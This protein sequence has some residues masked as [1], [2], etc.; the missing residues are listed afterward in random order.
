[1]CNVPRNVIEGDSNE[2][3]LPC[4]KNMKYEKRATSS[5]DYKKNMRIILKRNSIIV[6]LTVTSSEF[7]EM[8]KYTE[9]NVK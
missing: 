6:S 2:Y 1:V 4:L 7:L 9:D 8:V 5:A 3:P